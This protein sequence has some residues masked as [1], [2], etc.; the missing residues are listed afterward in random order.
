MAT[1]TPNTP[2]TPNQ[3]QPGNNPILTAD[4][5]TSLAKVEVLTAMQLFD[6]T[7]IDAILA[8]ITAECRAVPVDI[9]TEKGR[10]ACASLAYKLARTKTFVEDQRL[11]LVSDRK[12]ELAAIDTEARRVK[13]HLEALQAE[14]RKPLTEWENAEKVRVAG[15]ESNIAK[16]AALRQWETTPTLEEIDARLT[17]L[18]GVY[19]SAAEM[20]EFV[21]RAVAEKSL[22]LDTLTR[23][24]DELVE[25]ERNRKELERLQAEAAERDRIANEERIAREARE[26]AEASAAL[27]VAEAEQAAEAERVAAELERT[28]AA[29]REQ[30]LQDELRRARE[31]AEEQETL[32]ELARLE[33]EEQERVEAAEL[34]KLRAG[35]DAIRERVQEVMAYVASTKDIDVG[36]LEIL[37]AEA[38][39]AICLVQ[40]SERKANDVPGRSV[41][42]R[43]RVTE[44]VGGSGILL[45]GLK[46]RLEAVIAED[47]ARR[48]REANK[49][50]VDAVNT[51]AI[52]ALTVELPRMTTAQ[53]RA[54]VELI[55]DGKIPSVRIE[56]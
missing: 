50:H 9:S 5:I 14:V 36:D 21:A 16:L 19:A 38:D 13:G 37:R 20:Q 29:Q 54:V 46:E 27:Q 48:K 17:E 22:T 47:T 4:T 23:R 10:K 7:T 40:A 56:Y 12:R 6:G 41:S 3:H 51:A 49:R 34:D 43:A 30:E 33:R 39:E 44:M 11:K 18:E 35:H 42:F 15:H 8:V 45:S 52:K 2:N 32:A 28:A 25:A 31:A 1:N 55:A 53:A 26:R 24:R